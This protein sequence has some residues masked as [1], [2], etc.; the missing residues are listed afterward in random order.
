MSS[1]E[2]TSFLDEAQSRRCQAVHAAARVRATSIKKDQNAGDDDENL[3]PTTASLQ[4]AVYFSSQTPHDFVARVLLCR[5]GCSLCTPYRPNDRV[6]AA[7]WIISN[8]DRLRWFGAL[9]LAGCTF[10]FRAWFEYKDS[11]RTLRDLLDQARNSSRVGLALFQHLV[12]RPGAEEIRLLADRFCAQVNSKLWLFRIPHLGRSDVIR[13]F[14][15]EKRNNLPFHQC[16][17]VKEARRNARLT[18]CEIHEEFC[19]SPDLKVCLGAERYSC[20]A[21]D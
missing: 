13:E 4:E 19:S 9:A 7:R 15:Y 5:K 12:G 1:N 18:R 6:A 20:T 21:A 17:P 14:G 2:F 8:P 16:F 3:L 11:A 10:A